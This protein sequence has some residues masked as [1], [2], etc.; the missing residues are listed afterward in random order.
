M[1]GS[2]QQVLPSR[3]SRKRNCTLA[4]F[5]EK[6]YMPH[7]R[8]RKRSWKLEEA[9]LTRHVLPRL[10]QE[11]LKSISAFQLFSWQEWMKARNLAPST[12]NRALF[13]LKYLF[14]C[15]CS[16]GFLKHSPARDVQPLPAG[17]I[18]ERYLSP[19]EARRLLDAADADI[20]RMAALAVR[21]LLFTGARK[22]E[23]L[24]ARWEDVDLSRC[25]LTVPL[26]KSGRA[27]HIPL[28]DAALKTLASLPRSSPWL[29]PGASISFPRTSVYAAW[30]RIRLRAGL[31]DVRL[32]D[33]RHSFA[34]FLVNSGC[35]L[36]EVQKILGHHDPRVTTRYAHL[37]QDS[38]RRA[39][40]VLSVLL[41]T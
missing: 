18:R 23:I 19:E 39:A 34:S 36:Y 21:L 13:L 17:A 2:C 37:A 8:T 20:D 16:W 41:E 15:A 31:Q 24:K 1:S 10:G 11:K 32:H 27:H 26:A 9:I 4:E 28:S 7:A 14:N 40:N 33:L 6:V 25:L 5:A 12:C 22:S 3:A 35:T 30:N 29:F 38:L